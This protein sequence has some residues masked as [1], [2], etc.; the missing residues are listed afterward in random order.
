MSNT[1]KGVCYLLVYGI[2]F[3][4]SCTTTAQKDKPASGSGNI[5][6]KRLTITT[7]QG[8]AVDE[9]F[10]YAISNTIIIKCDK[11]TG[12]VIATWQADRKEK[13]YEH[14]MHLNSGTVIEGRLILIPS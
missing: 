14:F 9:K 2:V 5:V 3:F 6:L 8:V 1:A 7:R 10:F 11:E 13:A 4:V 12:R